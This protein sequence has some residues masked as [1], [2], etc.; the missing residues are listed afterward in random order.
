MDEPCYLCSHLVRLVVEGT[1]QWVNLEE[2]RESGAVVE[3]EEAV[4]CGASVYLLA[5]RQ[6]YEGRVVSSEMHSFGCRVEI[7]FSPATL[8]RPEDWT[9]EH[10]LDPEKL[11]R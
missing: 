6:F 2:I 9:P 1:E 5:E 8:W 4:G 7:E 10:L 3:C 11:K